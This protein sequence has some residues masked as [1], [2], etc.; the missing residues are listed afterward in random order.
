MRL[1]QPTDTVRV[2]VSSRPMV[3]GVVGGTQARGDLVER[4]AARAADF[5]NSRDHGQLPL[6]EPN[7][8]F[9][10]PTV[11]PMWQALAD[12]QTKE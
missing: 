3:C 5:A 2:P 9:L 7:R 6:S 4:H 1:S 11:S 12:R 10:C 8:F